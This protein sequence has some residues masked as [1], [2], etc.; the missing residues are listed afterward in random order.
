MRS[1]DIGTDRTFFAGAQDS[2]A[3]FFAVKRFAAVIG[4]DDHER[5]FFQAFVGGK[6]FMAGLAFAAAT[7]DTRRFQGAGIENSIF[8]M[9]AI[10]TFQKVASGVLR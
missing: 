2:F 7:D 6:A 9:S 8:L 10:W 4:F 3:Q 5:H 1:I